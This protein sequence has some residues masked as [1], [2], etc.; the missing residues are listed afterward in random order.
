MTSNCI[1]NPIIKHDLICVLLS[2]VLSSRNFNHDV[3]EVAPVRNFRSLVPCIFVVVMDNLLI[4]YTSKNKYT[5]SCSTTRYELHTTYLQDAFFHASKRIAVRRP[6]LVHIVCSPRLSMAKVNETKLQNIH[7]YHLALNL[8]VLE[9][10]SH[11]ISF[12]VF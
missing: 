6:A 9:E 11:V 10:L 4:I 12:C 7:I 1:R 8:S 5:Y 2:V 3:V